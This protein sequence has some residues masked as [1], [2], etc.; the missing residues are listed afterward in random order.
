VEPIV[1]LGVEDG[2]P[3]HTMTELKMFTSGSWRWQVRQSLREIDV[4][5]GNAILSRLTGKAGL[6]G[7][8]KDEEPTDEPHVR[9]H[10]RLKQ[11]L[12]EI[13]VNLA[14]ESQTEYREPPHIYDV[15]WKEFEGAPRASHVFEV[16]DKGNLIEALAK[17]QHARDIWGASLFLV[18]TGERDRRRV[19]E[20]VYPLLSGTFHRLAHYL[21][22]LS[23]E[24]IDDL[25]RALA[26][27]QE[28]LE[29]F[30]L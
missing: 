19:E 17:L 8:R 27:N 7:G 13:G 23:P 6:R 3:I 15:V 24:Q 12:I 1:T 10:E 2:I 25:H 28:L 30:L 4:Q 11:Q 29:K 5:D 22:V 18:V 20:H 16:Q 9:L 21:T 14:K 26:D